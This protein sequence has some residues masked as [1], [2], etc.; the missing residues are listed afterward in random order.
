[1]IYNYCVWQLYM[2]MV[3]GM[4]YGMVY[5]IILLNRVM[6][7]CDGVLTID[8]WYI[9]IRKLSYGILLLYMVMVYCQLIHDI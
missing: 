2:V 1:M 7:H 6:V 5:E 9:I 4:V 8:I 3:Y